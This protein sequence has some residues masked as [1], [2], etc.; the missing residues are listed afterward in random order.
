MP[1]R[2]YAI[3]LAISEA[4][5]AMTMSRELRFPDP[6]ADPELA[7]A[8]EP[9]LTPPNDSGEYWD[10]LH[11]RIMARIATV[12]A[13]ST[14]WSISPTMARAGLIAAGLALLAL[15]ALA[16]QTSENET[17]MAYQAVTGKRN[18]K[19]PASRFRE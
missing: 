19:S 14:W 18:S 10:G 2:G 9:L 11:R 15:G 1:G 3:P 12:G 13:P 16:L 7:A 17:R 5:E 6:S 4:S 8:L